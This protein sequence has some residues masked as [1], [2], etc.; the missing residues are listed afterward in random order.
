MSTLSSAI[1]T[2]GE[3]TPGIPPTEDCSDGTKTD[4]NQ[5]L[6]SR[7]VAEFRESSKSRSPKAGRTTWRRKRR[8]AQIAEEN[9]TALWLQ[10]AKITKSATRPRKLARSAQRCARPSNGSG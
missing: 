6:L 8:S 2:C 4:R 5:G 9:M 1:G 10:L 7:K 3:F